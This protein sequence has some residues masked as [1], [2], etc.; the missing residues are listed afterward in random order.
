MV[1]ES[2]LLVKSRVGSSEIEDSL[3][4]GRAR[5]TLI[6]KVK[7]CVGDDTQRKPMSLQIDISIEYLAS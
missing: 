2:D 3:P 1:T 4:S 5:Q 6:R 7:S